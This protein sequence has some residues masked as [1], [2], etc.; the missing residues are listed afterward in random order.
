MDQINAPET[1]QP[2][3]PNDVGH[4]KLEDL[5]AELGSLAVTVKY[6]MDDVDFLLEAGS[7]SQ[8]DW[9]RIDSIVAY[10]DKLEEVLG[11]KNDS[12]N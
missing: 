12:K 10:M 2:L 1:I 8:G 5:A 9:Q 7:F 11:I 3:T 4:Y 6:L